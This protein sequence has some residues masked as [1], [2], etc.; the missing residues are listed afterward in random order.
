MA[1]IPKKQQQW[2]WV[3]YYRVTEILHTR[4]RGHAIGRKSAGIPFHANLRRLA[5]K[6]IDSKK[7]FFS[8]NFQMA[9]PCSHLPE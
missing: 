3:G 8:K 4:S 5:I 6:R 7:C 1:D 2:L 9:Y